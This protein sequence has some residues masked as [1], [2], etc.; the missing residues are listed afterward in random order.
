MYPSTGSPM[1]HLQRSDSDTSLH[2]ELSQL[3]REMEYIRRECDA[4]VT[5]HL[6]A[7]QEVLRQVHNAQR[8]LQV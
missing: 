7:E 5:A 6:T 2:R 8:L 4:L 3:Q 1:Q